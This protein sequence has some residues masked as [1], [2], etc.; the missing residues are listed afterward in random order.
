MQAAKF[1]L[2]RSGRD[3]VLEAAEAVQVVGEPGV[4]GISTFE[5]DGD[6]ESRV[7][8]GKLDAGGHDAE[9]AARDAI[10]TNGLADGVAVAGEMFAP[11]SVAEDDDV[12]LTFDGVFRGEEG[13]E[14]WMDIEG[15]EGVCGYAGSKTRS[16][17][18]MP[19][20][21]P[22]ILDSVLRP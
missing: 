21:G 16:A 1:R 8:I 19:E 11:I 12:V 18:A 22:T 17:E 2:C 13:A 4:D 5:G 10:D 3:A 7:G 15:I 9:D 14:G 20:P 6:E